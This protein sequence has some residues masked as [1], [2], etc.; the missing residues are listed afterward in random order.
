MRKMAGKDKIRGQKLTT[1]ESYD[2]G[3]EGDN[4]GLGEF[5]DISDALTRSPRNA[6]KL[7]KCKVINEIMVIAPNILEGA[8]IN[9]VCLCTKGEGVSSNCK[10]R[11]SK[12][13]QYR[14]GCEETRKR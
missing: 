14:E 8:S 9:D 2:N 11:R 12:K 10:C 6:V 4:N 5:V 1:L 3:D 7:R 13:G